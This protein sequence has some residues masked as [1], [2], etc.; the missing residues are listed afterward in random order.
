MVGNVGNVGYR[1]QTQSRRAIL[2][3]SALGAG[4][5]GAPAALGALSGCAGEQPA[6]PASAGAV[7]LWQLYQNSPA[8]APLKDLLQQKHPQLQVNIV[9][10]PGGQMSQK[11][12][13]AAAGGTAPDAMSVN[14]PFFRDCAQLCQ[15]ID[16]FLKRDARKID[17]DDFLPIGLQA[18]TIKGKTYGLPLEVAVRVWWFNNAL[19]AERGVS[20]PVRPGAPAKVEHTQLEEMAQRL[21]FSRG[22]KQ[23]YGLWVH[24]GWFDLL[25]YVSGFGGKYL[26]ADHTRCLLDSP[27]AIAGMEYAFNLVDKRRIGPDSGTIEAHEQEGTLAMAL[28][29]AARAQNLRRG[30]HGMQWDVGPVVAGPAAPMTFAFVHHAGVVAGAKNPEGGWTAI[31]EYTGKDASRFWM[32]AHGW[33]AIRKSYL[34]LYIKEG[35]PP[36]TTR[37]NLLEWIK[38]SPLTTFPVGYTA[39]VAPIATKLVGEMNSGQRSVRD[40]AAALGREITAVLVP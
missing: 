6:A 16:S 13:V 12:T 30:E 19:L 14:A 25:I 35:Q 40:T 1:A 8:I 3:R 27:Q 9:D 15:P 18:S 24:R 23:V 29:N 38:V 36:P 31:G 11:L 39:N 34:D 37:A 10:V 28:G 22:D 21:T 2:R 5:A 4:L 33:P 20:S 17:V 26:D 7:E 32:E